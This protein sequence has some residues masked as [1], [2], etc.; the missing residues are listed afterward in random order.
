MTKNGDDARP[1]GT[2]E[3]HPAGRIEDN[4]RALRSRLEALMDHPDR[5][6]ILSSLHQL[7]KVLAE[8]FAD[9]EAVGGLYDDLAQRCPS[10]C[11]ELEVLRGQ[12]RA[13]LD[14]LEAVSREMQNHPE[15]DGAIRETTMGGV[16]RCVEKLRRHEHA[17]AKMITDV[18]Y[19]DEGGRG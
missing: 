3:N 2:A 10:I 8:H 4:H 13:I 11:K 18:Y 9:E 14:E 12:H 5:E 15:P 17:E 7:P 16:A 1:S 19:T 6:S